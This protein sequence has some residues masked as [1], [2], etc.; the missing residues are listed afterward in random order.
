MNKVSKKISDH[1]LLPSIKNGK[2]IIDLRAFTHGLQPKLVKKNML[3]FLKE[4]E[5][6]GVDAWNETV[7]SREVFLVGD[8]SEK[9]KKYDFGWWDLPELTG[10]RFIS[11]LIGAPQGTCIVLNNA[12]QVV[13]ELLSC[14]EFNTKNRN[15]VICTDREFP[16]VLHSLQHFKSLNKMKPKIV[17]MPKGFD[18]EKLLRELDEKTSLLIFSHIGFLNGERVPNPVIQ[19]ICK[20]AH[21]KGIFVAIDGYHAVGDHEI[22]VQELGV[23]LYFGGL[24]KRASGSSGLC[25]LYI[26]KGLELTP[27]LTGW[28]G[29]QFPF[30]FRLKP[31]I[32]SRV[33]RRFLLGTTSVAPF[34]HGFEGVKL[35]LQLGQSTLEK[36]VQKKVQAALDILLKGKA[37]VVSPLEPE[38]VS[39]LIVLRVSEAEKMSE[40]LKHK[41]GILV[42]SRKNQFLRF[43][44]YIYNSIEEIQTAMQTIVEAYKN[45]T[46]LK[47]THSKKKGPVT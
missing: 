36:D 2:R 34:Y 4:W 32:H 44:P 45:K 9:E 47:F 25:F 11:R 46:Y 8:E 5:L 14:K 18:E 22:N 27:A 3:I 12:T 13:L 33:R 42:D 1:F 40:Y 29:D 38:K 24:L 16:A 7:K 15:K 28:F 30:E 21:A 43:S 19:R 31:E 6:Q 35:F 10:D 39:S 23:D 17:K 26:R 41:Y 20:A 37:P